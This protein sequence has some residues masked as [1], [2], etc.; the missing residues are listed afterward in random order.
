M[1]HWPPGRITKDR[2]R[3]TE[4]VGPCHYC[5]VMT[6][7]TIS[8]A[9]R[10][11]PNRMATRDHIIP[12]FLGGSKDGDMVLACW[13]CNSARGHIPYEVYVY[14]MRQ[15]GRHLPHAQ[16]AAEAHQ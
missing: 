16:K 14:F 1:I 6:Y 9:A 13:S 15:R 10:Y 7:G 8:T 5:E 11:D 4:P 3:H 2:L 12:L